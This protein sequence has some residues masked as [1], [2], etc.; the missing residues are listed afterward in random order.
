MRNWYIDFHGSDSREELV[1][2]KITHSQVL[3]VASL[4]RL[5]LQP[6]EVKKFASEL[7]SILEY[8]DMLSGVD[9]AGIE[10]LHHPF[11]MANV[12]RQ[13]EAKPGQSLTEALTN[14]PRHEGGYVVVPKVIE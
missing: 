3:H 6:D 1:Q 9:T 4:A 12:F 14:A 10:P 2:M 13:D 5:E 11:P 8:M 7:N